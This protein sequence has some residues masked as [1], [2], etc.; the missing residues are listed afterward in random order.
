MHVTTVPIY[1]I[2]IDSGFLWIESS[3]ETLNRKQI[4]NCGGSF[5]SIEWYI[6]NE[7]QYQSVWWYIIQIESV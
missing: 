2:I 5:E 3:S 1:E 4:W 7:G 6:R